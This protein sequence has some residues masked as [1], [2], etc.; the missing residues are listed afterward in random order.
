MRIFRERKTSRIG[1]LRTLDFAMTGI[2]G[3]DNCQKIV[4]ILGLRTI[5]PLFMKPPKGN[6]RSG[7]TR[8]EN[9]GDL[10]YFKFYY[11]FY[12][13]LEHVISCIASLIR[14]CTSSNRQRVLNKFTENDH[15]KVNKNLI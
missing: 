6:K 10:I 12:S 3:K 2:E 1:A 5:F 4:D 14:N 9:E 7:E 13:I 15:E 11:L 8:A